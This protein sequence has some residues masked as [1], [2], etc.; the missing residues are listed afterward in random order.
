MN[1]SSIIPSIKDTQITSL[2]LPA[3][4]YNLKLIIQQ[5]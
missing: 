1:D 5:T 4:K 2:F 3:S